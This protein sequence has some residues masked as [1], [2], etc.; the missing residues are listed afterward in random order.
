MIREWGE[1]RK[2][3]RIGDGN[4]P[5]IQRR[6]RIIDRRTKAD[7]AAWHN[8]DHIAWLGQPSSEAWRI[9]SSIPLP[10]EPSGIIQNIGR[11]ADGC[12]SCCTDDG[13]ETACDQGQGLGKESPP[14]FLEHAVLDRL[15]IALRR[16]IACNGLQ[17]AVQAIPL[18]DIGTENSRTPA[19]SLLFYCAGGSHEATAD[20]PKGIVSV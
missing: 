17:L 3:I 14:G 16:T 15:A 13:E 7:L 2:A 4:R 12:A 8:L 18:R 19:P 11:N 10:K 6:G 9:L 1:V 20:G 5:A